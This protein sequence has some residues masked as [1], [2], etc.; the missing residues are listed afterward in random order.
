M[1]T[2]ATHDWPRFEPSK[3]YYCGAEIVPHS[4]ALVLE[5]V[6]PVDKPAD[7]YELHLACLTK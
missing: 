6:D 4:K 1:Q 5:I 2:I 3:C 7:F